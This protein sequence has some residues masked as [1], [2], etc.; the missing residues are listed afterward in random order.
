MTPKEDEKNV[1]RGCLGC[2]VWLLS[3]PLIICKDELNP[4]LF[5]LFL[6]LIAGLSFLVTILSSDK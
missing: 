2:S 4:F 1:K 6:L 5:T 3:I